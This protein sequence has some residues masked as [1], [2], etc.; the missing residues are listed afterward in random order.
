MTGWTNA[1]STVVLVRSYSR[2]SR[3]MSDESATDT[4]G[5][6]RRS[7]APTARSLASFA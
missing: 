2:H 1:E 6:S 3:Q 5:Q 7:S 4:S